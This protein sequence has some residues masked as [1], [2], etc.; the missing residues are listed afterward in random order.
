MHYTLKETENGNALKIKQDNSYFYYIQDEINKK[1][2]VVDKNWII[3]N[4]KFISNCSMSSR[5]YI[6]TVDDRF[7][8]ALKIIEKNLLKNI[9]SNK[10]DAKGAYDIIVLKPLIPVYDIRAKSN[11]TFCWDY[12]KSLGEDPVEVYTKC[13]DKLINRKRAEGQNFY[14]RKEGYRQMLF[15]SDTEEIVDE[16]TIKVMNAADVM[17]NL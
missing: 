12:I 1:T 10:F 15:M 4:R 16:N 17:N 14:M 13:L 3:K 11:V 9:V 8:K 7:V 6:Y 2:L 5:K